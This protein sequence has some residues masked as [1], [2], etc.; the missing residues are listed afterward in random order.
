MGSKQPTLQGVIV[1]AKFN[2]DWTD[3]F[4][5]LEP[6]GVNGDSSQNVW[7]GSLGIQGQPV[8]KGDVVDYI[9]SLKQ[10]PAKKNPTA[11]RVWVRTRAAENEQ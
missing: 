8:E 4:G 11:H 2:E 7:F 3:G 9:L 1:F 10:N 6:Y 5:F